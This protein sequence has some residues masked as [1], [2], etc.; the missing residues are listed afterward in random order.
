M[1]GS[2]L[3]WLRGFEQRRYA[4]Y[5]MSC[6]L[7]IA[8]ILTKETALITPGIIVAYYLAAPR[9]SSARRTAIRVGA[10]LAPYFA[11]AVIYLGVRRFALHSSGFDLTRP[12]IDSALT[13]PSALV[14][15]VKH[16]LWPTNLSTFYDV[17]ILTGFSAARVL[18]PTLL[19]LLIAAALLAL[20]RFSR[21]TLPAIAWLVLPIAPA[22]AGLQS[23]DRTDVVH[24]R[25]LYLSTIG[26]GMLLGMAIAAWKS[27]KFR[28][29]G[30]PGPQFVAIAALVVAMVAGTI[31]EIRPWQSNLT[32]FIQSVKA[33]PNSPPA[34]SHLAFEMY[35]RG[36]MAASQ[37]FYLEAV[38][39]DP[40][41]WPS[42]LGLA[43]LELRLSQWS[44][45]DHYFQRAI[46]I[47]PNVTNASYLMQAQARTNMGRFPEAE[48]S[49]RLAIKRIS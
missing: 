16:L 17:F 36:D 14:F 29:F 20:L 38:T 46:E 44:E 33:A 31:V 34:F 9:T 11:I 42:N 30:M 35:K 37:R 5:V 1:A 26:F 3:C 25:Y 40:N 32:L 7:F 22:I 43:V 6:A 4:L 41:D 8:A 18:W 48:S 23:F 24:D 28:F 19:V 10:L 12:W 15:Y 2:I 45:A 21:A 49:V 27:G 13:A 39:L 47:Q